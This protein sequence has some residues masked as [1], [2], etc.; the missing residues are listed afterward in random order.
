MISFRAITKETKRECFGYYAYIQGKHYIILDDA[1]LIETDNI[2]P[3][4]DGYVEIIPESLAQATD[5]TD[6]NGKIIFGSIEYEP[7]KMSMGGDIVEYPDEEFD[8]WQGTV[9]FTEGVATADGGNPLR[10][11]PPENIVIVFNHSDN[12]EKGE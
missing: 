8:T 2:T 4:I 10:N 7:G 11:Q 5:Q 12:S 6:K 1:E 3:M 9:E